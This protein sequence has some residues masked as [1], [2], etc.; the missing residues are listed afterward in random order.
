MMFCHGSNQ[1]AG[2]AIC[3]NKCPGKIITLKADVNE[4][5]DYHFDTNNR[6]RY[7]DIR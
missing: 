5:G 7:E 4:T 1:S 6:K 2:V 3:I